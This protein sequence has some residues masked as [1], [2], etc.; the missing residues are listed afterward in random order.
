MIRVC[1]W[2]LTAVKLKAM[3]FLSVRWIMPQRMLSP[4][5]HGDSCS[6]TLPVRLQTPT[7][8]KDTI[9]PRYSQEYANCSIWSCLTRQTRQ[10]KVEHQLGIN[11]CVSDLLIH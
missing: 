6:Q 5:G 7:A 11:Q 1:C 3:S 8:M 10:P 2:P 4:P 9:A